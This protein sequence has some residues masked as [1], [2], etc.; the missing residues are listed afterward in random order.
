MPGAAIAGVTYDGATSEARFP[1]VIVGNPK[2]KRDA[3]GGFA[4][5]IETDD[6]EFAS[7]SYSVHNLDELDAVVTEISTDH[8]PPHVFVWPATLAVLFK[9]NAQPLRGRTPAD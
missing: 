5:T 7:S 4:V 3:A 9:P 6:G 8:G 2:G 1:F